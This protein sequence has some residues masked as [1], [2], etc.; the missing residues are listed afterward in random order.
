MLGS[1][2]TLA[3]HCG[4][5]E[6]VKTSY[7]GKILYWIFQLGVVGWLRHLLWAHWYRWWWVMKNQQAVLLIWEVCCLIVAILDSICAVRVYHICLWVIS[8]CVE[9]SSGA[10]VEEDGEWGGCVGKEDHPSSADVSLEGSLWCK[11][12]HWGVFNIHYVISLS[13]FPIEQPTST[14]NEDKND[15][16][17]KQTWNPN[18]NFVLPHILSLISSPSCLWSKSQHV[19][20]FTQYMANADT[21]FFTKQPTTLFLSSSSSSIIPPPSTNFQQSSPSLQKHSQTQIWT[22][23]WFKYPQWLPRCC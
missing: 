10:G 15:Q 3:I 9:I 16:T 2:V 13:M 6:L 11:A 20:F 14:H 5:H 17:W 21:I 23:H 4:H 12:D 19:L 18:G 8:I 7:H 1:L 22:F